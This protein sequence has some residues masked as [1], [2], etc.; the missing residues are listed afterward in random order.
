MAR[1]P[2]SIK[3][4]TAMLER[5]ADID[6]QVAAIEEARRAELAKVNATYDELAAPLLPQLADMKAKLT[7]WWQAG[8]SALTD[9][10]RKSIALGGCEIGSRS[11]PASLAVDGDESAIAR[12]LFKMRWARELVRV[13]FGLERAAIMKS[14][15]GAHAEDFAELGLSRRDGDETVFVKRVQ[16]GGTQGAA[17][18][19]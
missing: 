10:K 2:R 12:A 5:F 14:L 9:G 18:K 15:D 17:A 6:G 7:S 8:G 3:G 11:S 19:S 4:A 16:Q 13:S 1:A